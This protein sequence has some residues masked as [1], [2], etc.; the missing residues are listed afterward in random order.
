MKIKRILLCEDSFEGVLSAVYEAYASRYGLH[1]IAVKLLSDADRQEVLFSEYKVVET[2]IEHASSVAQT[3]RKKISDE[4]FWLVFHAACAEDAGKAD[5][6]YR[7]IVYGLYYGNKVMDAL[8]EPPVRLV[9]QLS[10]KVSRECDHLYGFLR[11]ES[12]EVSGQQLLFARIQPKHQQLR[13][14]AG[15]FSKRYPKENFV[16]CDVGRRLACVHRADTPCEFLEYDAAFFQSFETAVQA[17][18]TYEKLWCS[19]FKAAT[20]SQRH[21]PRCQMSMMPKRY[22]AYMPEMADKNV[23]K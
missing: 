22:W 21:N 10:R 11:F 13:Q 1:D 4:A 18:D 14:M 19:F 23:L 17:A 15:H 20:I 7:F 9:M 16:I 2:D 8:S 3:I 5:A 6:I 12:V